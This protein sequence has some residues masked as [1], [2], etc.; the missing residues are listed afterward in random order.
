MVR[1]SQEV[2]DLD[3]KE[4]DKGLDNPF[5]TSK[6]NKDTTRLHREKLGGP[7]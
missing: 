5:K 1:S 3:G 6:L 2:E 4:K 7:G